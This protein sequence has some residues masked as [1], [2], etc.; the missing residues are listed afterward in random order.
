M[1]T[2]AVE[3]SGDNLDDAEKASLAIKRI[4]TIALLAIGL[5]FFM[6]GLIL[7]AKLASG[8]SF[9]NITF[10]ADLAQGV[11]WSFLVCSGVGIATT[12]AKARAALAGLIAFI[13]APIAV[14][15]AKGSQKV[16]A[17]LLNA[18]EQPAM[19]SLATVSTLRAIEYGLLG[20]LLATLIRKDE[21][22]AFPYIATG[23]AIGVIFGGAIV[24]ISYQVALSKGVVMGAPQLAGS[25]VNEIG[26][27]IG[28]ALL[29]Y[30][31]QFVGRNVKIL[32][33][34]KA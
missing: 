21:S 20:W 13:F 34:A 3:V 24:A 6:Q 28:C 8:G 16:M 15:V 14:A 18:A 32:S 29:I 10:L 4:G 27:P 31:G 17:G 12:L 26:S 9:P 23:I 33:A 25:L 19:L 2:E 1:T 30:I 7:T 11:T 5:G 22:R